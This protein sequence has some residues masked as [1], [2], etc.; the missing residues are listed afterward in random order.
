MYASVRPFA[1]FVYETTEQIS[2]LTLYWRVYTK[3]WFLNSIFIDIGLTGVMHNLH[4]SQV[5]VSSTFSKKKMVNCIKYIGPTCID[6][7]CLK[8]SRC[9]IQ[10][11][12]TTNR[13]KFPFYYTCL[14]LEENNIVV[15][16]EQ[17]HTFT[18]GRVQY[19]SLLKQRLFT[20]LRK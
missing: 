15:K 14:Y 13:S 3:T 9:D 8:L 2:K 5:K 4:D 18:G 7:F 6:N 1:C 12:T 11:N 17:S 10:R 19:T 16:T 20:V